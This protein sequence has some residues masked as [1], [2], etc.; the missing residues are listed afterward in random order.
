M[1]TGRGSSE[2]M[3]IGH[4][5]PFLAAKSLQENF[6]CYVFIPISDDEKFFVKEDLSFEDAVA[7]GR[8]NIIDL[9]ALGFKQGKTFFFQDFVN[10]EIYRFAA[11]VAKKITYS[12]ARAVFGLKPESNIGWS[13]YPAVQAAH[14]LMPQWVLDKHIS[15]VPVG[16]D[17]DP[18][19][20]LTRDVA[21][22]FNFEKPAGLY[23]KFLPSLTGEA[24]MS[25]TEK[26]KVIWLTDNPEEVETKIMKYAFSGG[27]PTL[28]LHKKLGGNPDVDV[29]FQYLKMV[30]EPDDKKL[31]QIEEN[32]RSGK[33]LTTE[34]KQ[35]LIEKINAFLKK[36]QR[37]RKKASKK[38]KKFL[39]DF[40][41]LSL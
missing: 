2:K 23:S 33:L 27:Q 5:I 40:S 30:F 12:T 31:K 32:Y 21:K 13:F 4:L 10:T 26:E 17:Q 41:N 11:K 20:R 25:A 28:E 34:L 16:I 37:E 14:I 35:I 7:Y 18:F 22:Y 15:V 24:K 39:L 38:V 29:S 6:N 19:I 3:H 8:D 9:I 1:I 36:H